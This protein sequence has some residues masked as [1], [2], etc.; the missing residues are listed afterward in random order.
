MLK[1]YSLVDFDKHN[2]QM[3]DTFRMQLILVE[4]GAE[5]KNGA[6]IHSQNK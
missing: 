3:K 2:I 4:F 6:E 1:V 5:K